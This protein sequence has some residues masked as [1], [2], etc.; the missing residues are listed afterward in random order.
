MQALNVGDNT[1]GL[2][3]EKV[4]LATDADVDGMHIR[5]SDDRFFKFFRAGGPRRP[6]LHPGDAAVPRAPTKSERRFIA[7]RSRARCGGDGSW[8]ANRRSRGSKV[9]GEI[10]P[11][12]KFQQFI[13]MKMRTEQVEFAPRAGV[14]PDL[15]F[16]HGQR[17]PERKDYIMEPVCRAGGGNGSGWGSV[18]RFRARRKQM[19]EQ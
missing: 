6:R 5:N 8:A 18:V 9:W 3:C 10:Q 19:A 1:E 12:K 16:L 13:G 14:Q 15:R 4:I 17:T 2:R 11:E 7:T